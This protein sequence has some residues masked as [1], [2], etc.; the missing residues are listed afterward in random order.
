MCLP[1][2][3]LPASCRAWEHSARPFITQHCDSMT[4]THSTEREILVF[5]P[6]YWVYKERKEIKKKLKKEVLVSYSA[7][8][9]WSS[10]ETVDWR[11]L[12]N[13]HFRPL[14]TPLQP[15]VCPHTLHGTVHV[16]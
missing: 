16:T 2:R 7:T 3:V 10:P 9:V 1:S 15:S 5:P 4:T 8:S 12:L 11:R 6:L 13:V 14:S